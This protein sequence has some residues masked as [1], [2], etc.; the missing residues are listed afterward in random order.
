MNSDEVDRFLRARVR[1]FDGA[2]SVDNL[3]D[4]LHLLVCNPDPSEEPGRHWIAI[5]IEDG[6][7]EFFDPFGHDLTL[8]LNVI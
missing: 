5:Y 2:F 3:P 6:R 1:D 7:G 4:D 8:T